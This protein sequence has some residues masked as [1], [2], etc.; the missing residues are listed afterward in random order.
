MILKKITIQIHAA[1]SVVILL[2]MVYGCGEE[3]KH[4][5]PIKVVARPGSVAVVPFRQSVEGSPKRALSLVPAHALIDPNSLYQGARVLQ[6]N[7][8]LHNSGVVRGQLL[9][10]VP[11]TAQGDIP[12]S[13]SASGGGRGQS[14][15]A[16]SFKT[17]PVKVTLTVK[18]EP[19]SE[20]PP[21]LAG[22]WQ[23]KND[24]WNFSAAP[25]R[26][27][28]KRYASG[29][30]KVEVYDIYPDSTGRWL[31][32]CVNPKDGTY[33]VEL[34]KEGSLSV[35]HPGKAFKPFATMTPLP[36]N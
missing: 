29:E 31:L 33:W 9:I 23:N 12:F 18:G 14:A 22:D 11:P 6:S 35:A 34:G 13:L 28:T 32:V 19:V 25:E 26:K 16:V 3:A 5:T 2:F 15:S 36:S 17:Q 4:S 1:I 10:L 30:E 27:L 24:T 7:L 20:S 8:N 21:S